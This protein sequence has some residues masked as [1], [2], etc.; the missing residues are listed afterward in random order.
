MWE[1]DFDGGEGESQDSINQ[2]LLPFT[3]EEL[4]ELYGRAFGRITDQLVENLAPLIILINDGS[5][6]WT[7][8]VEVDDEAL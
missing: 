3:Y 2:L 5:S 8:G 6:T 1:G 4:G 7:R